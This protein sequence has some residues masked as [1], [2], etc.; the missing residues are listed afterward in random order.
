MDLVAGVRKEG[1]RYVKAFPP[2]IRQDRL[3]ALLFQR[4]ARRVQSKPSLLTLPVEYVLTA[5]SGKMFA[6]P[7]TARTTSDTPLWR[8]WVAGKEEKI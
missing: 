2:N 3:T 5:P 8:P 1:S 6:T 7:N 4:W